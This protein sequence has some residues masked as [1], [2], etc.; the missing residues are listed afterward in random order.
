MTVVG[1]I[2]RNEY[3]SFCSRCDKNFYNLTNFQIIV[4]IDLNFQILI[5]TI[6]P[7]SE[8]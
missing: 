4:L 6:V 3:A 1:L 2:H 8:R 7:I 5:F